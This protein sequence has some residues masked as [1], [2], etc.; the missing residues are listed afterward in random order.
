MSSKGPKAGE[1]VSARSRPAA[2]SKHAPVADAVANVDAHS[3]VRTVLLAL[4]LIAAVFL[5]YG[6]HISVGGFIWDDDDYI[7]QNPH[8]PAA[9]GLWRIWTTSESPQYYPLV[10]STLWLEYRL[11]GLDPRGYHFVN[12]AFHAINAVLIW[13]VLRRMRFVGAFAV[14]A[15]FAL[16]PMHVETVA[17]AAEHKNTMSTMFYLLALLCYWKFDGTRESTSIS[18]TTNSRDATRPRAH[19]SDSPWFWYALMLACFILGLFCKTVIAT[20]PIAIILLRYWRGLPLRL[21]DIAPLVPLLVLGGIMGAITGAYEQRHVIGELGVALSPEW[22]TSIPERMINAGR[23]LWFYAAKIV[24]PHPLNFNYPRWDNDAADFMQ[25]LW[26]LSAFLLAAFLFAMRRRWGNGLFAAACFFAISVAPALGFV[27]VAP[28]RYSFVADHFCYLPSVGVIAAIVGIAGWLLQRIIAERL[29][30]RIAG[31]AIT[32]A[33]A[34]FLG[35][36]AHDR[37]RDYQTVETL[38]R[39]TLAK[40]DKSWLARVNLGR[41]LRDRGELDEAQ[42]HFQRMIEDWPDWWEPVAGGHNGIGTVRMMRGDFEGARQHFE[43]A[44][45]TH[46]HPVEGRAN[47]GHALFELKRDPEAIEQFREALKLQPEHANARLRLGMALERIG[48]LEAAQ[49]EFEEARRLMPGSY[50][51]HVGLGNIAMRKNVFDRAMKHFKDALAIEPAS[52][53][54]RAHL[55]LAQ[56]QIG[57]HAEAIATLQEGMSII[58]ASGGAPSR[59]RHADL[60]TLYQQMV[61]VH[62]IAA[63]DQALIDTVRDA[64]A[65]RVANP[66]MLLLYADVLATAPKDELRNPVEALRI[67]EQLLPNLMDAHKPLALRTMAAAQASQGKFDMARE[68]SRQALQLAQA[69]KNQPLAEDISTRLERYNAGQPFRRG[70]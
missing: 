46:K 38:W 53:M 69:Q 41:V 9:D 66:Q 45:E 5:A 59:S 54:I 39:D 27:N 15:I 44:A 4:A 60:I 29:Q 49:A 3:P 48:E 65:R 13:T 8:L 58:D 56:A 17:W 55:A 35:W 31:A 68:T 40:N 12:V 20:L 25:W 42:A 28:F 2:K 19:R 63:D 61:V 11:W 1:K 7:F 10:F 23:V 32:I 18:A 26:P 62:Q 36:L 52:A 30:M 33:I 34:G 6:E 14:A 50:M 22:H 70:Q 43:L 21:A 24:W 51:P 57:F 37:L 47:L 64:M 67:A 16:H